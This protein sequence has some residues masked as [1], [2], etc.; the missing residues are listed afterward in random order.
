M[1]LRRQKST[2]EGFNVDVDDFLIIL[3]KKKELA[4]KRKKKK[5]NK[6]TNKRNYLS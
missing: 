1:T 3:T 2:C 5:K 6:P 4:S